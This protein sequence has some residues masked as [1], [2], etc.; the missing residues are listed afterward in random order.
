[1]LL[2][3]NLNYTNEQKA[4]IVIRLIQIGIDIYGAAINA[5]APANE[6]IWT[7]GGGHNGGR[8][9]PMLFAGVLLNNTP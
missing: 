9:M 7:H 4:P 5:A 6:I 8:K 1:M 3:A 2:A